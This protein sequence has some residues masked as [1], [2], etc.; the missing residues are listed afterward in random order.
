MTCPAP[1][2]GAA[3]CNGSQCGFT[4]TAPYQQQGTSCIAV[5]TPE[6]ANTGS[7]AVDFWTVWGSSSNDVYAAGYDNTNHIGVFYR[8]INGG[9]WAAGNAMPNGTEI[10]TGMWGD[11]GN[12]IYL[13]SLGLGKIFYSSGDGFF[14]QVQ[15]TGIFDKYMAASV[16]G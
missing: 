16:F 11:N 14:T 15:Q 3:T 4:C 13:V 5:F 9:A 10:L 1:F 12:D 6:S 8:K 2:G 7:S